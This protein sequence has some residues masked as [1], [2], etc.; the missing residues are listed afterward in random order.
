MKIIT[1]DGSVLSGE[2]GPTGPLGP[3]G[4]EGPLNQNPTLE[5]LTLFSNAPSLLIQEDNT[6]PGW[7]LTS[8]NG[9]L[10][11][12][13]LTDSTNP[14]TVLQASTD[15]IIT[16]HNA[17]NGTFLIGGTTQPD[18]TFG[19]VLQIENDQT[20]ANSL[21]FRKDTSG[22]EQTV[23]RIVAK[24]G[25]SLASY[26]RL[27]Q[28][29]FAQDAADNSTGMMLF[30]TGGAG[31][32]FTEKMR[33]DSDGFLGLGVAPES[34]INTNFK[35]LRIGS[36]LI[37]Q[38]DESGDYCGLMY[39]RYRAASSWASMETGVGAWHH[40]EAN[41]AQ[42]FGYF[43]SGSGDAV[44]RMVIDENGHLTNYSNIYASS[45]GT[46]CAIVSTDGATNAN[47]L[48]MYFNH[49]SSRAE[50]IA[51]QQN[52]G[53]RALWLNP[54]GSGVVIGN[55]TGGDKGTGTLNAQGVYD[56]N[57]LLTCY[58]GEAYATGDI[59]IAKWD[60]LVPDQTDTDVN[61]V[62]RTIKKTHER[63]RYIKDNLWMLDPRKYGD[64]FKEKRHLAGMP[65]FETWKHGDMPIGDLTCRLWECCELLTVHIHKLESQITEL[66][67]EI[68]KLKAS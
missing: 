64:F 66:K 61:G 50:I 68:E 30:Y 15:S 16:L 4:P 65:S 49:S 37:V 18:A 48:I 39:N 45:T 35:A 46:D 55:P 22:T 43:A 12:N 53:Y 40:F 25:N 31:G 17:T 7:E 44:N 5:S 23:G 27:A 29:D 52:V 32:T 21:I 8:N 42:T 14:E 59:N 34:D 58:V 54:N 63:A 13:N 26:D 11:I 47:E 24:S 10:Q 1:S 38:Y 51:V 56:D 36:R 3:T 6:S 57:V 62:E 2:I 33:I 19:T 67:T 9:N 20:A 41:G 60:A 28:I